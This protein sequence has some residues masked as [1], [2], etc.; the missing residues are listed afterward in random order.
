MDSD[1]WRDGDLTVMNGVV[2]RQWT[3]R[4]R[5]N[6]DGQQW[7]K[8]R[9]LESSRRIDSDGRLLNGDGR[10]GTMAMDGAVAP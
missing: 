1:G 10:R 4:Q 9:R 7:M 6:S 2:R 8:R 5:L 3:A